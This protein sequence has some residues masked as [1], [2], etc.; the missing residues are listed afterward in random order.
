MPS[1]EKAILNPFE[2]LGVTEALLVAVCGMVVVFMMLAILALVI[3]VISKALGSIEGKVAPAPA[4]VAAGET[5]VNSP[6]P[7]NIFKVECQV[8]Q[9]VKAGDV[10]VVLE[11]MKMEIEVSAPV[12]GTVK[13]VSAVVGT[14]VNTDDLLVTLG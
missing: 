4:A 6:M 3:I 12:D 1:V 14:A 11:A 8:G 5:A 9:A 13:A 10:L 7:G 2:P